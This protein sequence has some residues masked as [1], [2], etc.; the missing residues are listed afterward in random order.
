METYPKQERNSAVLFC[1]GQ[2]NLLVGRGLILSISIIHTLEDGA[3]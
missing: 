1:T 3:V 2:E